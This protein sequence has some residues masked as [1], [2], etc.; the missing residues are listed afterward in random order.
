[1]PQA[2]ACENSCPSWKPHI[3]KAIPN[4]FCPSWL[5]KSWVFVVPSASIYMITSPKAEVPFSKAWETRIF[6]QCLNPRS[7]PGKSWDKIWTV[8]IFCWHCTG[9]KI[10]ISC[11]DL[12]FCVKIHMW[13]F[14]WND[15]N[16]WPLRAHIPCF[17]LDGTH[18]FHF[19]TV[20]TIL[21]CL[22]HPFTFLATVDIGYCDCWFK[23]VTEWICTPGR[24][25]WSEGASWL[26]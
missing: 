23:A 18:V 22:P 26:E 1:M 7:Y 2:Q 24:A 14:L 8:C 9:Y 16:C 20:P 25:D 13:G 11:Q 10:L 12:I 15:E 5:S 21:S 4:S 6:M 19:F 3:S 17:L